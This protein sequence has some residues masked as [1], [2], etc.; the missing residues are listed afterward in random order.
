MRHVVHSVLRE[1]AL[2]GALV[3]AASLGPEALADEVSQAQGVASN[4]SSNVHFQSYGNGSRPSTVTIVPLIWSETTE[5]GQDA[6][7]E[8]ASELDLAYSKLQSSSYYGWLRMEYNAPALAHTYPT[9]LNYAIQSSVISDSDLQSSLGMA[10]AS[11]GIPTPDNAL[12]VVHLP[13]G[14]LTDKLGSS[15]SSLGAL[16]YNGPHFNPSD[17]SYY[18]FAVIP[19]PLTCSFGFDTVTRVL[20]HEVLEEVTDQGYDGSPFDGSSPNSNG[21]CDVT[22]PA[23]CDDGEPAQIGDLCNGEREAATTM[24][25]FG[26]LTV[27]KMWSNAMNACVVMDAQ[28]DPPQH[29][30]NPPNGNV[31]KPGGGVAAVSRSTGAV[32]TFTIGYDGKLWSAGGWYVGTTVNSNP[33]V[34]AHND[35]TFTPGGGIAAVSRVPTIIDTFTI[36]ND[37]KLWGVGSFRPDNNWYGATPIV[38]AQTQFVFQVGGGITAVSRNQH[39]LDTFAIGFDGHLWDT[40][41]FDDVAGWHPAYQVAPNQFVFRPGGGLAAIAEDANTIDVLTIGDDGNLWSAGQW[42]TNHWNPAYPLFQLP[43]G[44]AAP[45]AQI[46]AVVRQPGNL[47]DV[48]IIGPDGKLWNIEG[49][50]NNVSGLQWTNWVLDQTAPSSFVFAPGE[51]VAVAAREINGVQILLNTVAIGYDSVPWSAGFLGPLH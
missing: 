17:L 24:T 38:Q 8:L 26:S 30:L 34:G 4:C 39:I 18:Y 22:Q 23:S 16:G 21:W 36:G 2:A 35:F 47:V 33:V 12:Y 14:V 10:I 20:S 49:V 50:Y 6:A 31:F 46:S 44:F 41:W 13:T 42:A 15:C 5:G 43:R 25:P 48:V 3:A 32:D 40:G 51:G 7:Q 29:W 11:N 19:D 45:G 9:I 37:G 1:G 27:Q 28:W